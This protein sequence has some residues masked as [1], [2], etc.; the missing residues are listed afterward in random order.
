MNHSNPLADTIFGDFDIAPTVAEEHAAEQRTRTLRR[1][2]EKHQ[3][4]RARSPDRIRA[5]QAVA[6]TKFRTGT[7]RPKALAKDI[8][9]YQ[10]GKRSGKW[11]CDPCGIS[12]SKEGEFQKHLTTKSHQQKVERLESGD[13]WKFPCAPCGKGWDY[14]SEYEKHCRSA[15]HKTRVAEVSGKAIEHEWL[16]YCEAC[17]KGFDTERGWDRHINSPRH[18]DKEERF[19]AEQEARIAEEARRVT[20]EW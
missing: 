3:Q 16:H 4:A 1:R 18:K 10:K 17:S 13:S 6:D 20:R 19:P 11:D 15:R 5:A 14:P 8:R 9:R 2:K 12:C 7:S